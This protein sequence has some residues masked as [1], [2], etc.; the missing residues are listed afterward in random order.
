MFTT[1]DHTAGS[2]IQ[3]PRAWG[4]GK[5]HE[6]HENQRTTENCRELPRTTL[7]FYQY[8]I[9]AKSDG[10]RVMTSAVAITPEI[11]HKVEHCSDPTLKTN[12]RTSSS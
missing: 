2:D 12:A 4:E 10:K 11:S 9:Y 3:R 6:N 8:Y 5:N 1:T 7:P